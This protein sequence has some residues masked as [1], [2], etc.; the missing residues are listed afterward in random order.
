MEGSNDYGHRPRLVNSSIKVQE[1]LS[2]D[3]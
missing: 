3:W 2:K 1:H